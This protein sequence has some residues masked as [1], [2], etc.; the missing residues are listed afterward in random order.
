MSEF[1]KTMRAWRRMCDTFSKQYGYDCCEYCPMGHLKSCGAMLER[2]EN[3]YDNIA[4]TVDNW[5]AENP[6]SQYPTWAEW[7]E[8]M[9]LTWRSVTAARATNAVE[10]DSMQGIPFIMMLSLK[11]RSP[12]PADIAEKLGLK[13][14]GVNGDEAD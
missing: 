1:T 6:E 10:P 5:A 8:E 11:A 13:P 2:E 3:A 12:I 9:G 4:E 14:K 7:L